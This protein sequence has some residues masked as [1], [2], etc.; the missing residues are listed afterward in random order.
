[1]SKTFATYFFI[2][3]EIIKT[4]SEIHNLKCVIKV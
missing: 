2:N 4:V 3:I 1:M